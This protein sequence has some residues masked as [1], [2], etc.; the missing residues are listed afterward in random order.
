MPSVGSLYGTLRLD[1]R[2]YQAAL[3]TNADRTRQFAAQ[4][5]THFARL[6]SAAV[7]GSL[8]VAAK[9]ALDLGENTIRAA[10]QT[11]LAVDE[12]STFEFAARRN[13][14][15]AEELTAAIL[16]MRKAL[17]D[18]AEGSTQAQTRFAR[19]GL[20]WESLAR[21]PVREQ[22]LA[23]ARAMATAGEGT[24]AFSQAS[25]ILG[26]SN[27]PRL[28]AALIDLAETG[29]GQ[30]GQAAQAAGQLLTEGTAKQLARAKQAIDDLQR[31]LTV[32]VGTALADL[33][34]LRDA[35]AANAF[36]DLEDQLRRLIRVE[37]DLEEQRKGGS[38]VAASAEAALRRERLAY[39]RA[40]GELADNPIFMREDRAI[41]AI[42][43]IREFR[44]EYVRAGE[45]SAA[46]AAE[47]E[48]IYERLTQSR[49]EQTARE[50]AAVE[51]AAEQQIAAVEARVAQ[52]KTAAELLDRIGAE[53]AARQRLRDDL[54][55]AESALQAFR[56]SLAFNI[57]NDPFAALV[58]SI[59][60]ANRQ[61]EQGTA[62]AR[63][64]ASALASAQKTFGAS[65]LATLEAGITSSRARGQGR[66]ADTAQRALDRARRSATAGQLGDAESQLAYIR[67]LGLTPG[68]SLE[69]ILGRQVTPEATAEATGV[70][71][72]EDTLIARVGELTTA[73]ETIA[74]KL[75][76]P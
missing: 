47:I 10:R 49:A 23:V 50:T 57:A 62:S 51:A 52:E 5:A 44:E 7:L 53:A 36:L 45:V 31:S 22:L 4:T 2:Q 73:L 8:T 70:S 43:R 42:E 76:V 14:S 46:T 75:T 54:R 41:I 29:F 60:Q 59:R 27:A 40:A 13:Q 65:E 32:F 56:D 21:L 16:S 74:E 28:T 35:P 15:S 66:T 17:G 63:A 58:E 55:Q 71:A 38:A 69:E 26:T 12:F 68:I 72:K 34:S 18:A 48:R 37:A 20:D 39:I 25:A 9:A 61:L 64:Y 24:V 30:V 19:L 33:A 11:G 1:D 67:S 6:A 3:K